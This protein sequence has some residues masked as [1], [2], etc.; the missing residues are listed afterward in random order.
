M[1]IFTSAS[2]KSV[3]RGYDYYLSNKV[4]NLIKISDIEY[5]AFVQGSEEKLYKVHLNIKKPKTS[6]CDCSFANGRKIC[7]HMMAVYFSAF[8]DET[9]DYK[10]QL[11]EYEAEEEER[12]QEYEELCIDVMDAVDN[13][14][15]EDAKQA[16]LQLLFEG[17]EWQFGRFV[18]EWL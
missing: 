2:G 12:E 9:E 3:Y 14:S 17:P 11:E 16:L 7:K 15:E 5:E 1:S 18:E 6:V 10:R 8:P 13:M 4:S